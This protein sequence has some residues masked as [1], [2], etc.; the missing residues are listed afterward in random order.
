MKR[1]FFFLFAVCIVST[2]DPAAAQKLIHNS[3]VT[4]VSLAGN[5]TNRIYIP[6]PARFLARSDARGKASIKIL[7]SGFPAN[8]L[9][10]LKYATSI[11]ES[12]L[13][14]G[15]RIT[16]SASWERI[17]TA[18]VL[19][20]SSTTG[21]APGWGI[22]AF[23]PNVLYPVALA[24]KIAGENLNDTLDADLTLRVNNTINW[25]FGTDGNT[26]GIK[27]DLV[28]VIIHEVCHGLGFYDS[29]TTTG[30]SGLYGL[31]GYPLIYDVFTE[32]LF[33]KKLTD[34][35]LFNNPSN[36]LYKE[37]TGGN[38]YFS[39]PLLK[40]YLSGTRARLYAPS[41]WD[42]GSSISHLDENTT[43]EPNTLMTPFI[44]MGEAIHDPGKLTMSILGDLGWINTRI[45][46]KPLHDTETHLTEL[47][48]SASIVSDTL[49]NHNK[50][51]L[52][53]S[54][55]GFETSD[56]LFMLS[57]SS[58]DNYSAVIPVSSYNGK[59]QYYLFT[60]DCFNRV[61]RNP[62][63]IDSIKYSTYIG[64]DTVKPVITHTPLTSFLE[65]ID[66]ISFSATAKDNLG[67][68]TIY[69][70]YS[71]NEEAS[72]FFGLKAGSNSIFSA[73]L[74]AKALHLNGGD[75][76]RYRIIAIDSA[77]V[78]NQ[79]IL[80]SAG[81]YTIH[82]EDLTGVV[83][84]YS[85]DF[86]GE[87]TS[88]F[89]N[90]GFSVERPLGFVHY[91]LN[92]LHPYLSPEDNSK[93]FNYTSILR[94][95]IKIRESGLLIRFNEIVLVEPGEAGSVFGSGDFYDYVAVEGSRNFG[96][97]WF[98]LADGYDSRFHKQWETTYNSA[99][100]GTNSTAKGT[101][102]MLF[103]H[104]ILCSPSASLAAGDTM[105]IRFRLFS[106]PFAHGWGWNIE[107]LSIGPFVDAVDA[108]T[109][110]TTVS[111]Y[112]NPGKG[113]IKF[114]AENV[115]ESGK[116][117]K[118]SIL[119][120]SGISVKSDYLSSLDGSIIDISGYPS[121]IY[122]IVLTRDDW[123]ITLRYSLLK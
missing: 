55:D 92:S 75:S 91:G 79:R 26:P 67:I 66:T 29:F 90:D 48:V 7:Q 33:G 99:T 31:G 86:T 70:E 52:V 122:Y 39:G 54:A 59:I 115:R 73:D 74:N 95:P 100:D 5:R 57:A 112:P 16:L 89:I 68:D 88:D 25:Y 93:S 63:L 104:S 82:I 85:T 61:F 118:Y 109:D 20:N 9:G 2:Y 120:A 8:A 117:L 111:I 46:H 21:F 13:P 114:R 41:T 94:H 10:A 17:S 47:P 53:W 110:N 14:A 76:I 15:T 64:T 18:G 19:A 83:E 36:D 121:G 106:D 101:E 108:V 38:V 6:P 97:T 43:L 103:S 116:S 71:V 44:D 123:L 30:T 87:E 69:V 62:S 113:V 50:V 105:L 3:S 60:E 78:P 49:Y 45:A 80:P 42:A 32:N 34:T 11:L 28:T 4:G 27:Y 23:K 77:N 102:S 98:Y 40:T 22:N 72:H 51:C 1:H 107:D 84:S 37:L 119:N 81:F 96:K 56:T 12:V 65:T 35:L 58:D 24:E